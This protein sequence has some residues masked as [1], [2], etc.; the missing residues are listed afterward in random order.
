MKLT[1][2]KIAR[3][4]KTN[5]QSVKKQKRNKKRRN[6]KNL[7]SLNQK[8]SAHLANKSMK[9]YKK[10]GEELVLYVGGKPLSTEELKVFKTQLLFFK[11]KIN[12][13]DRDE[14]KV[15]Y[16]FEQKYCEGLTQ[17]LNNKI[18]NIN[19]LKKICSTDVSINVLI[20]TDDL[21]MVVAMSDGRVIVCKKDG[22]FINSYS[23]DESVVALIFI[24]TATEGTKIIIS[25]STDGII[26][27]YILGAPDATTEFRKLSQTAQSAFLNRDEHIVSI[28]GSS[29]SKNIL[30]TTTVFK[31]NS[32]KMVTYN[33][34]T[35]NLS[36]EPPKSSIKDAA[37]VFAGTFLT[38]ASSLGVGLTAD[39]L[40]G[41][42]TGVAAGLL[43]AA[44]LS[45]IMISYYKLPPQ[46]E[47]KI[48]FKIKYITVSNDKTLLAFCTDGRINIIKLNPDATPMMIYNKDK[49]KQLP[50]EL[51][52]SNTFLDEFNVACFTPN[53]QYIACGAGNVLSIWIIDWT[54]RAVN[55]LVSPCPLYSKITSI[56]I[57]NRGDNIYC[58]FSDG[59]IQ[60]NPH[61]VKETAP[62]R[63]LWI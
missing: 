52:I 48:Q 26:K 10:V 44:V 43:W 29:D 15:L 18:Y 1:K 36:S 46:L 37:M 40:G 55:E 25:G 50:D 12:R 28:I 6:V 39:G 38:S 14:Y 51:V 21:H 58:G 4:H 47:H 8:Q 42:E 3:L 32:F 45:Y 19:T 62:I 41:I 57:D 16:E 63:Y 17:I 54:T 7:M 34:G 35:L 30:V 49:S 9:K 5:R 59:S 11:T 56:Y 23:H 53:N 2:G 60:L 24:D 20:F 33:S 13:K 61:M 22:T 31:E 27:R